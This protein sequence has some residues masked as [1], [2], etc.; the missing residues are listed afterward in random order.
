VTLHDDAALIARC[1]R[2]DRKAFELLVAQHTRY[3]GAVAMGVVGDYHAA[4]DVI[5]EA[6]IKVM[7]RLDTLDDPARFRPWLR[8]VVRTTALDALRRRKVVGR[9]G[10]SLPGQDEGS[11][12]LPAPALRPEDALEQAELREQIRD[13]IAGLPES[14]RE[15]VYLKYIEGLSYEAIAE[16]TGLTTGTIESRLFR[17]RANLRKRLVKRFGG[18]LTA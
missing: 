10:E 14:Q 13:E 9:S 11:E 5:Q 18:E 6:F 15:V 1:R 16:A 7:N 3:A 2:G 17:A 12:P 4:L 8:N